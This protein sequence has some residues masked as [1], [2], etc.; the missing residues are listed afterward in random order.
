MGCCA[1]RGV[2]RNRSTY[3]YTPRASSASPV[4]LATPMEHLL[5]PSGKRVVLALGMARRS[6]A[7]HRPALRRFV[8][9]GV[10]SGPEPRGQP[11]QPPVFGAAWPPAGSWMGC[12]AAAG[13]GGSAEDLG[14]DGDL[15]RAWVRAE[16]PASAITSTAA[17]ASWTKVKEH[18]GRLARS[19]SAE[20]PSNDGGRSG[21]GRSSAGGSSSRGGFHATKVGHGTLA[22]ARVQRG[23]HAR[24]L[25]PLHG[26]L[27]AARRRDHPLPRRGDALL[28]PPRAARS[29]RS[30]GPGD[31]EADLRSG[32][33]RAP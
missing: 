3:A 2:G 28:H 17:T 4:P 27:R 6:R 22:A 19:A 26:A 30:L 5:R 31:R 23:L 20:R 24:F 10:G 32:V 21:I 11:P 7:A 18:L 15:V 33:D 8:R 13:A 12:G 29:P 14:R 25:F 9:L 1:A 16:Q